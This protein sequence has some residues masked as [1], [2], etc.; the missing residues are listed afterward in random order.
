M[1]YSTPIFKGYVHPH[2]ICSV[3]PQKTYQQFHSLSPNW[4]N[5]PMFK[6][7]FKY[8]SAEIS[9]NIPVEI[10]EAQIMTII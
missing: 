6:D 10:T 8:S 5:L 7:S 3:E 4:Q 2:L 1:G 9:N